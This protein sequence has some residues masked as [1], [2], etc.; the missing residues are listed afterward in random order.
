MKD[1]DSVGGKNA[2]L[3]EMIG[4]LA[5]GG[6]RVPDGFAT[7]AQAYRDFL[8][9][10]GLGPRIA[11]ELAAL[12]VDDVARL[13]DAGARIRGW[14]LETPFQPALEQEVLAAA[15]QLANG[16]SAV[17][18]RSSATAEDLPG[19]SFAGQQETILNVRGERSVLA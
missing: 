4:R 6:V 14:I 3:G 11:A 9:Q 10:D 13:A 7:T 19:A 15:A 2:S 16:G 5:G 8:A 12:D 18:V 1:V 17:A